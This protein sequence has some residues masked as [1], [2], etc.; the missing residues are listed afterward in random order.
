MYVNPD[1]AERELSVLHEMIEAARFGL[2]VVCADGALGAHIPFVLH[3]EGG[4]GTG[5]GNGNGTLLGHVAGNDPIAR[6]LG[7][8]QEGQEGQEGLV[9]FSGPAAYVSPRWYEG[10]GLAGDGLPTYNFLAVHAYGRP[11]LLE[12]REA[13]LAYLGEL[14]DVHERR[15]P[16]PWSLGSASEDHVAGLLPHIVAFTFEIEAIQGKRKLSQ[17]KTAGDRDGVIRG[18]RERGGDDEE[19]IAEEMARWG[20]GE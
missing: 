10:D 18:L 19:A 9:V 6:H 5:N 17:N 7:G 3:R 2:L 15:S 4:N 20:G 16:N 14:V 13:V 1:Y 8:G 11:R 12:E